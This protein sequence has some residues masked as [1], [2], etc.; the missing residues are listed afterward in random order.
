MASWT[1]VSANDAWTARISCSDLS[2][3]VPARNA[4][5]VDDLLYFPSSNRFIAFRLPDFILLSSQ[6][7]EQVD[8]LLG[9]PRPAVSRDVF[10]ALGLACNSIA[11][12]FKVF[13]GQ[14]AERQDLRPGRNRRMRRSPIWRR[15]QIGV[16]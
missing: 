10:N 3:H 11:K 6:P 5:R 12:P 4:E 1:F 14:L 9:L 16:E 13:P 2:L 7:S 8:A 15:V